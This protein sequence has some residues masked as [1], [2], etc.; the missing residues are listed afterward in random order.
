MKRS[1][2]LKKITKHGFL[3]IGVIYLDARRI[4]YIVDY[5]YR[6]AF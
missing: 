2:Y 1:Y 3:A 4:F 5:I 6:M